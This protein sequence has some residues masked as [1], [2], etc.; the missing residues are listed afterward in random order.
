MRRKRPSRAHNSLRSNTLPLCPKKHK[1]CV[2]IQSRISNNMR[3]GLLCFASPYPYAE[4]QNKTRF[5]SPAVVDPSSQR[6]RDKSRICVT[7]RWTP[8]DS[9]LYT[10]AR[11]TR[12]CV[13][14][15]LCPPRRLNNLR[16]TQSKRKFASPRTLSGRQ[17][18]ICVTGPSEDL[19]A[20]G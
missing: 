6:V 13:T 11:Q 4:A 3:G 18:K 16:P 1:L 10:P 14:R 9:T 17:T 19:P 2:C 15:F 7:H 8:A 12:I 20:P 5:A